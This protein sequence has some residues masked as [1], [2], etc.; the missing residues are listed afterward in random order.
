MQPIQPDLWGSTHVDK[1]IER[2]RTFEPPEGYYLAFSGG[3]DSVTILRLAE[4]AGVKFDAHYHVTT[5]D[6]PELVKFI[7]EQHPDVH[8]DRP[9]MSMF[10]LILHK[11][12]PPMRRQVYCCERLKEHGG[13][14]RVVVQGVRWAESAKRKNV[15][16][17]VELCALRSMRT[18]NPIIDWSDSEV[19]EFIRHEKVPYC[20]LYDEGWK[21]LGCILCPKGGYPKEEAKRWPKIAKA[22][23]NTFDRLLELRAKI[24]KTQRF[25]S[26]QELFDWWIKRNTKKRPPDEQ[27]RFEVDP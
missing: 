15:R 9:E 22:Y 8:R 17:M 16:K 7:K 14:G 26:G 23:I 12:W 27:M 11:N 21:R 10:R 13:D 5:V 24:G 18:V 3:K 4:M 19:W 1:A 25:E 6:P 20:S 2:L